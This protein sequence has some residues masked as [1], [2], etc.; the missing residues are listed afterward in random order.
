MFQTQ[1]PSPTKSQQAP[2]ERKKWNFRDQEFPRVTPTATVLCERRLNETYANRKV[3]IHTRNPFRNPQPTTHPL[4]FH[5]V[6]Y[7][8]TSPS[9]TSHPLALR[10]TPIAPI[11]IYISAFSVN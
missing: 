5:L 11:Q 1:P 9:L 3:Q 4:L 7:R 2:K 10:F 8:I 6:T